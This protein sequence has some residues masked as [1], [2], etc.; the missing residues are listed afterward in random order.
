[1]ARPRIKIK[2]KQKIIIQP[3]TFYLF[4]LF[5]MSDLEFETV[6]LLCKT[7]SQSHISG[8]GLDPRI[9]LES[10]PQRFTICLRKE[11]ILIVLNCTVVQQSLS[12]PFPLSPCWFALLLWFAWNLSASVFI[13][14]RISWRKSNKRHWRAKERKQAPYLSMILIKWL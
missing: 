8:I 9:I 4:F 12:I 6:L 2:E 7:L 13:A 5:Q 1:M 14:W 11:I 3:L 10:C